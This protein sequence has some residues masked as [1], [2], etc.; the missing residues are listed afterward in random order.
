LWYSDSI[1]PTSLTHV[2][3]DSWLKAAMFIAQ[4]DRTDFLGCIG[5]IVA[6][7]Q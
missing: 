7:A 3:L 1:D 5:V 6:V 2:S 4:N